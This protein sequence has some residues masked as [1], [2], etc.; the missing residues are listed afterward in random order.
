MSKHMQLTVQVRP[1]YKKSLKADYTKIAQG[2]SYI[3]EAWAEEGPSLFDIVGKLDKLLYELEGNPPFRKILLEH[4]DE[5][6]KL[7]KEVEEHIA[8]W[9]LAKADKMLYQIEDIFDQIEWEL[10]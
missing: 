9:D 1:Y 8:D 7:H 10:R 5:L 3:H 6:R 2:L 4:K